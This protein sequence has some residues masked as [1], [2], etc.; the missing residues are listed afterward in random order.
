[1]SLYTGSEKKMRPYTGSEILQKLHAAAGLWC[2]R[3][4]KIK[5]AIKNDTISEAVLTAL[6]SSRLID[7][8]QIM[9]SLDGYL[10][11]S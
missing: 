10:R 3:N 7:Y 8:C 1:M 2:R 6:S 4:K 5:S 9:S 11:P